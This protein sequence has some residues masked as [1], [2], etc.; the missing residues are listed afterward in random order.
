MRIFLA[1]ASG[2]LG[3]RLVPLLVANGHVVHAY[4]IDEAARR[5]A[6]LLDAP[7]GIVE[8]VEADV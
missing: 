2:V 3:V 5:T 7:S 1:G 4:Q 6:A 8:V